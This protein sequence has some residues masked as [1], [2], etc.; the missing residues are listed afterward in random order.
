MAF[1]LTFLSIFY[2]FIYLCKE[3]ISTQVLDSRCVFQHWTNIFL[4]KIIEKEGKLKKRNYVYTIFEGQC[5]SL[6]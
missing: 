2:V 5:F 1:Q 4:S 6:I 3:L